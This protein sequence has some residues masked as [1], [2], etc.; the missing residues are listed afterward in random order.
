[1]QGLS[2][3]VAGAAQMVLIIARSPASSVRTP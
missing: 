2:S 1:M 3:V